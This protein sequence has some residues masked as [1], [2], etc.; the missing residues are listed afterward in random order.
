MSRNAYASHY[1]QTAVASAV[2][3]ADPHRLVA[4]MFAGV[5]ERLQLAMACL[6]AG[7]VARKGEAISE[8]STIVGHL[9][10][11]LD[12]EAG[13]DIAANLAALY[14]YI[15]RRMLEANVTGDVAALAE[16]DALLAEIEGAWNSIGSAVGAGAAA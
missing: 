3:D 10:G 14:D 5:R 7:N 9:A 13:G 6:E 11:S 15:Q 1:R 8:A 12:M 4:L 2:L 16:C